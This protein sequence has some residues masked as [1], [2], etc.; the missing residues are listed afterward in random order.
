MLGQS[1]HPLTHHTRADGSHYPAEECPITNSLEHLGTVRVSDEVFWRKDG[2][3]FP[4]DYVARPQ[5][6][7]DS[8]L[9]GSSGKAV[10]VVVAFTD[11]TER[12][13]LD[14]MKD[15]FISTVSHELRTPLTSLRAALGLVGSGSL[16]TR[17]DKMQQMLKIAV[18]NTERLVKSGQRHP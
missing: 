10:G 9:G 11:V 13:A 1:M 5:I 8:E 7:P 16:T 17:P 2:S 4:V 15:D 18:A 14:R 6:D 12:Q 3:S